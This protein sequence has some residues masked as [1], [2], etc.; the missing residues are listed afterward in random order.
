M[1]S[2]AKTMPA[3]GALKMDDMAPAAPQPTRVTRWR[4]FKE[5]IFAILDP[6]AAPLITTGASGP[7]EPP[8]PMVRQLD[9]SLEKLERKR[10]SPP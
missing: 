8:L 2:V 3:I 9:I 7:A 10:N 5:K 1:T 6:M 4:S